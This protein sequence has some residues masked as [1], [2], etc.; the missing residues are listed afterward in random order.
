MLEVFH[1]AANKYKFIF[2]ISK[3]M[4]IFCIPF[5]I[6]EIILIKVFTNNKMIDK[7]KIIINASE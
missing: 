6:L 4:L 7:A 5:P 2:M 3:I 1:K